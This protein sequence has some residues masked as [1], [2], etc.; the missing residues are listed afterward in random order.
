LR[1]YILR[2]LLYMVPTVFA[3]SV[4]A[5]VII[6]LPPG[7]YLTTVI[8]ELS[9]SG[10]PVDSGTIAGLKDRFGLGDPAYVQYFKWIGGIVL[11]GDFGLSF[12][13]NVPVGDLIWDRL[14]ATF[15]ISL[16]TLLLIWLVAFPIGIFSAVRKYSAADYLF[17]FFGFLGLATPNFLLALVLMYVSVRYFGQSVGGLVSPDMLD[18]PWDGSKIMDLVAH[19]WLPVFVI[20]A[21]GMAALIRIMRA[22]LLDELYRPYVVT[23]RAKGMSEFRLLLKYPVRVALN[24]FLSTVGWMLPT[25][26]SGEIV[27]SVVLSLPTTGPMLLRALLSQDMYLAGSIILVA[28]MMTVLG[29]LVSDILLA[30]VDP[31]IRYQ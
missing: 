18:H 11:H 20:G 24:P 22:N 13:K 5:F 28:S 1:D 31:R 2:R 19:I 10:A 21:S 9:A 16:L 8:A 7:D 17:T 3:I 14:G 26:V 4:M 25:L 6:R 29:T 23:A 27:V 15:G 30:W 12:E